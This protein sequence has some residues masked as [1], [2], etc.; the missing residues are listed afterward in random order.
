MSPRFELHFAA[1]RVFDDKDGRLGDIELKH[2]TQVRGVVL[3]TDGNPVS[4]VV[5]AIR[6]DRFNGQVKQSLCP[7]PFVGPTGVPL[8]ESN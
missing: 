3:D 4:G 8:R 2:G 7:E 5:V 1:T 6:N